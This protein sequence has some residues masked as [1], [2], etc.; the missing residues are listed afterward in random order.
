LIHT[1]S[2]HVNL[3]VG[4]QHLLYFLTLADLGSQER[5]EYKE[6]LRRVCHTEGQRLASNGNE[7]NI[8]SARLK[9]S[10]PITATLAP[11]KRSLGVWR[12]QILAFVKIRPD[13]TDLQHPRLVSFIGQLKSKGSVGDLCVLANIV[14]PVV[15]QRETSVLERWRL[16]AFGATENADDRQRRSL[17]QEEI[18]FRRKL[19]LQRAMND[20][21]VMGFA[22][23]LPISCIY[24]LFFLIDIILVFFSPSIQTG[25]SI[26]IQTV[27]LGTLSPNVVLT[28]IVHLNKFSIYFRLTSYNWISVAIELIS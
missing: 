16:D 27:G 24:V 23:G 4:F 14:T 8:L 1:S 28:G 19:I 9:K 3:G 13:G 10:A 6:N 25:Q 2:E 26:L 22:K 15:E 12:P 5:Q 20:E 17:I 21:H 7:Q 11:S 18:I